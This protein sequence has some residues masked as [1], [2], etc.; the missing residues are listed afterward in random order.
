VQWL[1]DHAAI[2]SRW[3]L[4]HAT[5]QTPEEITRFA[6]S[7]AVAG[8]CPITEANLGDGLA[9]AAPFVQQGG[10]FGIG[11]DSNVRIGVADELQQLEYSQRLRDRSRN[12]L[13]GTSRSTGRS[14]FEGAVRGG[15]LATGVQV[16]GRQAGIAIGAAADFFSLNLD[17]LEFAG[18]SGDALLDSFVFAGGKR[19]IDGVWRAGKKVVAGGQHRAREK[20][21][22]NYRA[23]LA[24]LLAR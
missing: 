22:A 15:A 19:A 7:G 12:V 6:R 3:C 16:D 13:S 10:T 9:P 5:H 2:D 14:L 18:R 8:F 4:V 24:R 11:T 17:S 21:S 23:T 1:L 20:V